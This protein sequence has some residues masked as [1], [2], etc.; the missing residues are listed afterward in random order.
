M[1]LQAP[2]IAFGGNHWGIVGLAKCPTFEDTLNCLLGVIFNR[3]ETGSPAMSGAPPV[4]RLGEKEIVQRRQCSQ[5]SMGKK[6]RLR[7]L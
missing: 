4:R 2:A 7:I 1:N 5:A 3:D 6:G